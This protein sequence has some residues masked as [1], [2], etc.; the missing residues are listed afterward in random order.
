MLK[1]KAAEQRF[2][3]S[4]HGMHFVN[5]HAGADGGKGVSC[6]IEVRHGV[7][8]EGIVLPQ[9]GEMV[10]EPS[11]QSPQVAAANAG[12]HGGDHGPVIQLGE[13]CLHRLPLS[14]LL[15]SRLI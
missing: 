1:D 14:L 15:H 8:G 7:H 12:H 10:A 4:G 3:V 6:K 13:I 11:A 5:G 2:P 9:P